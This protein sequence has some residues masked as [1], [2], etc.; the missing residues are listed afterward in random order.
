MGDDETQQ[1]LTRLGAAVAERIARDGGTIAVA[2]SLTGGLLSNAFARA[3]GASGWF[4]GGVV[5]YASDV[6]H[7]LLDVPPGPVVSAAAAGA[8]A[9]GAAR[10]LG[11]S[12]GVAVTGAGGPD[13]QDG[14]PPGTVWLAVHQ[15]DHDDEE[16]VEV[17]LEGE[18]E[19]ICLAAC[20]AALRLVLDRLCSKGPGQRRDGTGGS[21]AP[22]GRRAV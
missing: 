21:D 22:G 12:I 9:M 14:Q 19:E 7:D 8:L 16:P 3:E 4:R 20:V 5:A 6:K 11:A 10:L 17:R 18:P 13:P 1:E 15:A 2:E